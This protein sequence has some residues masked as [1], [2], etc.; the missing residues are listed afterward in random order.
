[1]KKHPTT[2]SKIIP[3]ANTASAAGSIASVHNVCHALCL[4]AVA[5]LSI[6]GIVV[7]SDALMWLETFSWPFWIM[8]I[9]FLTMSVAFYIRYGPC[10][11]WRMII[12]NT[13]L[14]VI[15]IPFAQR[16]GWL[17]WAPGIAI[18]VFGV[19]LILNN[20]FIQ[21]NEVM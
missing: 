18:T 10:I 13:G 15:G 21:R 17:V 3:A 6:F 1:M 16:F 2:Q 5:F 9:I 8:G 7:A 14:L 19:V 12:A 11:S 4:G 20:R